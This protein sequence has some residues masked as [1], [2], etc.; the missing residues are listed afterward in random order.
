MTP[1]AFKTSLYFVF[2]IS[3]KLKLKWTKNNIFSSNSLLSHFYI[4][5]SLSKTLWEKLRYDRRSTMVSVSQPHPLHV[6][7]AHTFRYPSV[8]LQNETTQFYFFFSQE[9]NSLWLKQGEINSSQYGSWQKECLIWPIT[10]ERVQLTWVFLVVWF[11]LI[12]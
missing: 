4:Q 3:T 9:L 12:S 10:T 1:Q 7:G 8:S 2:T 6:T 5:M 11:G